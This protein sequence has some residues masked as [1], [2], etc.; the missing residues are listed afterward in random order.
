MSRLEF[1]IENPVDLPPQLE[2][3]YYL[4]LLTNSAGKMTPPP[5]RLVISAAQT[6]AWIGKTMGTQSA[7]LNAQGIY[8]PF[9][10]DIASPVI[11]A[12]EQS[13]L[14]STRII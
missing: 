8:N 14:G 4:Y 5:V 11:L 13:A 12:Y 1:T 6:G 2:F 10:A 9:Q 7:E 3:L